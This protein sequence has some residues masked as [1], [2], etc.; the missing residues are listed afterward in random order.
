MPCINL[1]LYRV[2]TLTSDDNNKTHSF[3][4][5]ILESLQTTANPPIDQ[6]FINN[7]SDLYKENIFN[8]C[9]RCILVN[10]LNHYLTEEWTPCVIKQ[11]K[12]EKLTFMVLTQHTKVTTERLT[13][14]SNANVNRLFGWDL[15]EMKKKIQESNT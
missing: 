1:E 8:M 15:Y 4:Q 14:L 12:N 9:C 13:V 10:V 5:N 3:K 7:F 2:L 6:L 11:Y